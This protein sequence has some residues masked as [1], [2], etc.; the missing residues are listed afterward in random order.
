MNSKFAHWFIIGSLIFSFIILV[1][2][3]FWWIYPY[4]TIEVSKQPYPV[5]TPVVKQGEMMMYKIDYCKYTTAVATVSKTFVD[6]I[7][8]AIPENSLNLPVGC[9]SR[10]TSIVVPKSLPVGTYYLRILGTY[11]VNPIR[12]ITNE[13]TTDKFEVTK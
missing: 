10:I 4:K 9:D 5:I 11:K 1:I 3:L 12:T 8:Y 2:F 6:G 7:V 13:Y